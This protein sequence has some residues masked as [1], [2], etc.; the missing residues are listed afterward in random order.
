MRCL[1]DESEFEEVWKD[2]SE[3]PNREST[4]LPNCGIDSL[5]GHSAVQQPLFIHIAAP[6]LDPLC[7]HAALAR[8]WPAK[9]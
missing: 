2:N 5:A 8:S 4:E 7:W 3:L 9:Q 6:P 1:Q